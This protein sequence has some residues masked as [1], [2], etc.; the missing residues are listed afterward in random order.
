MEHQHARVVSGEDLVLD[1]TLNRWPS[2]SPL[3]SDPL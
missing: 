2:R 3:F 1:A